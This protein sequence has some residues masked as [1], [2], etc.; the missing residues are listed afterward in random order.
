[1]QI[2]DGALN[3]IKFTLHAMGNRTAE[4]TFEPGNALRTYTRNYNTLNQL[5]KDVN[6]AGTANVGYQTNG[7]HTSTAALSRISSSL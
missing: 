1:M 5:W 4:N 3:R 6:A 7:N 2:Q